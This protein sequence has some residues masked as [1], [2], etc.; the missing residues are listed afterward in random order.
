MMQKKSPDDYVIAT[1]ETHSVEEF[2]NAAF[3]M[4][5]L[6]VDKYVS[7]NPK[8]YRPTEV[9]ELRGDA[10]KARAELVWTPLVGFNSLVSLMIQSDLKLAKKERG[11]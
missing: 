5:D 3:G 2:L 7:I 10:S 1:G 6:D 8:Y 4:L 9:N 11:R